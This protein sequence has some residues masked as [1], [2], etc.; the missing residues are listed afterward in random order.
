MAT[1]NSPFQDLSQEHRQQL[2]T[3][4]E[5]YLSVL[6]ALSKEEL[7]NF[8]WEAC[9]AQMVEE[10]IGMAGLTMNDG[11]II[12]QCT[13]LSEKLHAHVN[14]RLTLTTATVKGRL[15]TLLQTPLNAIKQRLSL[16][17]TRA[18]HKTIQRATSA[19]SLDE[20]LNDSPSHNNTT[21]RWDSELGDSLFG[22]L[23]S[24]DPQ[25]P[26]LL[27]DEEPE[28]EVDSA[29]VNK[30][31]SNSSIRRSIQGTR[32]SQPPSRQSAK[33]KKKSGSRP[34]RS[35]RRSRILAQQKLKPCESDINV[36]PE[37]Q[38]TPPKKRGRPKKQTENN[39]QKEPIQSNE[40]TSTSDSDSN[41]GVKQKSSNL[42]APVTI[43][44][45]KTHKERLAKEML[46]CLEVGCKH[47]RLSSADMVQCSHCAI[48]H[49]LDCVDLLQSDTIGVWPCPRCRVQSDMLHQCHKMLQEITSQLAALQ[50]LQDNVH[51]DM[52]SLARSKN[53]EKSNQDLVK[54]LGSKTGHCDVLVV[55]NIRLK[56]QIE[57]LQATPPATL[58][59]PR[60][61]STRPASGTLL[62]GSSI[63]R[64]FDTGQ[65]SKTA[66][67][68]ISGGRITPLKKT[69]DDSKD[70]YE[71]VV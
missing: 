61:R 50:L 17:S 6:D 41:H 53:L 11:T 65:P 7:A 26:I 5:H 25:L 52:G 39:P 44:H 71:T 12:A 67:K 23:S 62:L 59:L 60:N 36:V 20:L 58:T 35:T 34:R 8:D 4:Y 32:D 1:A 24:Q 16:S 70:V 21:M 40:S 10:L 3:I 29:S 49:H 51:K 48:W 37:T 31:Q 33:S 14:D 13:R 55:E 66:V 28:S 22:L 38:H 42:L 27:E 63:I 19:N 47:K 15:T 30:S 46:Y 64:N 57:Q 69:L 45:K 18:R 68:S 2:L 9:H 43:C 54:L 56:R